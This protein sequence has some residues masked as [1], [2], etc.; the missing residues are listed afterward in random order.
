MDIVGNESEVVFKLSYN[1]LDFD[2]VVVKFYYVVEDI[3][4]SDNGEV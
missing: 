2:E 3:M 4:L 1:Y